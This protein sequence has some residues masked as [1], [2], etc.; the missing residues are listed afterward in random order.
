MFGIFPA[1]LLSVYLIIVW[2]SMFVSAHETC[3]QWYMLSIPKLIF[4]VLPTDFEEIVSWGWGL[5]GILSSTFEIWWK[6]VSML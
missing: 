2:T 1:T 3:V 5:H 4:F 6:N